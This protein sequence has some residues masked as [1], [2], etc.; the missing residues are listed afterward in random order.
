MREFTEQSAKK[1]LRLLTTEDTEFT[2][3]TKNL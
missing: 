1:T 2:E 3:K